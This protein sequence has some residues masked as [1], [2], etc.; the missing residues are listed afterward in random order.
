MTEK[1]GNYTTYKRRTT[2]AVL[3]CY[4]ARMAEEQR[5]ELLLHHNIFVY[6]YVTVFNNGVSVVPANGLG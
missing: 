3:L 2:T 1:V 6:R 4:E 5:Q